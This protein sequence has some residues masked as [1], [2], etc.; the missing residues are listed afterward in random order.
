MTISFTDPSLPGQLQEG[1]VQTR[2]LQ[3]GVRIRVNSGLVWLTIAG[4]REDIWLKAGRC[5]D[6]HGRGEAIFRSGQRCGRI[7]GHSLA[8]QGVQRRYGTY[9]QAPAARPDP[10]VLIRAKRNFATLAGMQTALPTASTPV[11][12]AR[13]PEIVRR[14]VEPYEASFAAMRAYTDARTPET[15]TSS[16]SSS[17]PLSTRWAWAPTAPMC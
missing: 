14:G 2:R 11:A 13:R 8:S 3:G 17:I 6:F 10:L 12:G 9:C 1:Q 4:C 5:F 7:H 16:G 15:P